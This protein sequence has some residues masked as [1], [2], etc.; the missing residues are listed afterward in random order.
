MSTGW[1]RRAWDWIETNDPVD[2]LI[3]GFLVVGL[4]SVLFI[5][6]VGTFLSYVVH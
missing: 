1:C 4:L 6:A 3:G 5:M 2:T